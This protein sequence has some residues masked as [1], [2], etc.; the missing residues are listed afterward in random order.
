VIPDGRKLTSIAGLLRNSTKI[1][2]QFSGLEQCSQKAPVNGGKLKRDLIV[3][4][5]SP[6]LPLLSS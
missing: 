4:N 1:A 2:A 6:W 5:H 3:W